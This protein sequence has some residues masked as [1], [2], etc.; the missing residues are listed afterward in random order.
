[1]RKMIWTV[2]CLPWLWLAPAV[3]HDHAASAEHHAMPDAH[4]IEH[5]MKKQFDKPEAPLT[6]A[7]VSIEG[8]YAVA[9][10]VQ[11]GKGGRALLKKEN[12]AW[13]IQVCGGDGLKK[14]E[15]LTSTGMD[16]ATAAKLAKKLDAAEAKLS[17]DHLSKLS[18]FEGM[19]K[20]DAASHDGHGA[21]HKH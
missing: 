11:S 18:M 10:W 14:P 17:K 2:V 7:P 12:G 20:V 9:G 5:T 6:V 15:T 19:V 16:A 4:A 13:Q 1:M 3:A 21:H 8:N